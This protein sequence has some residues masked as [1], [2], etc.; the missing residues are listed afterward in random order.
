MLHIMWRL[1]VTTIY[2]LHMNRHEWESASSFGS[3]IIEW[4]L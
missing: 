1:T 3:L 4:L 2:A